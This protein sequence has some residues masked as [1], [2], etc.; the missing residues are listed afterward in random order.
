MTTQ[1]STAGAV[2]VSHAI[3]CTVVPATQQRPQFGTLPRH[4]RTGEH[5]E[6]REAAGQRAKRDIQLLFVAVLGQRP[7]CGLHDEEVCS[8]YEL[9]HQFGAAAQVERIHRCRVRRY[10]LGALRVERGVGASTRHHALAILENH[11]QRA[12]REVPEAVGQLGDVPLLEPLP[13]KLPSPSN[14]IFPQQEVAER[15]GAEA[16][17]R[18]VQVELHARTLAEPLAAQLHES[19]AHTRSGNGSPAASS[20]AGQMTQ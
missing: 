17:D 10:Y 8:G 6:P 4:E 19:V 1:P 11:G 15:I 13:V 14:G 3:D 18:F 2:A 12:R 16:V 9:T 20:I 7:G 5:R